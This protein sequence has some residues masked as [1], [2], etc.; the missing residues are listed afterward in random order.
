MLVWLVSRLFSEALTWPWLVVTAV[1]VVVPD[2]AKS[3]IK[4]PK[5]EETTPLGE[6]SERTAIEGA[7][8]SRCLGFPS[9]EAVRDHVMAPALNMVVVD[10]PDDSLASPPPAVDTTDELVEPLAAPSP[11]AGAS[12]CSSG[13]RSQADSHHESDG[14]SSSSSESESESESDS[15]SDTS[16]E[17]GADYLDE[18]P[19]P[20]SEEE[21][22]D[23]IATEED[24]TQDAFRRSRRGQ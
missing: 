14:S 15:G 1:V 4:R 5:I 12:R 18:P 20:T 6:R 22:N 19:I 21:D 24:P 17:E 11:W 13:L 8:T 10:V 23:D 3:P 2:D 9:D 16:D 7:V